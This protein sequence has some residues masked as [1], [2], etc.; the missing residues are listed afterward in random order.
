MDA[1]APS[2]AWCQA[3]YCGRCSTPFY[4][5]GRQL[6]VLCA[7]QARNVVF[8]R[9]VAVVAEGADPLW[10]PA[11]DSLEQAAATHCWP[12]WTEFPRQR[13]WHDF[14]KSVGAITL[15]NGYRQL[16]ESW[17]WAEKQYR[18]LRKSCE[19]AEGLKELLLGIPSVVLK[20]MTPGE[21]DEL[22]RSL[23]LLKHWNPQ[24]L[25]KLPT[26]YLNLVLTG[27]SDS[28]AQVTG[29]PHP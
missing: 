4:V 24:Y 20:R 1:V 10:P 16:K 5:H 8:C 25:L 2:N 27:M 23:P 15:R 14:S 18:R 6:F 7:L 12:R 21:S 29:M 26:P 9:C 13:R 17:S 28:L 19:K 22:V 11:S 3:H